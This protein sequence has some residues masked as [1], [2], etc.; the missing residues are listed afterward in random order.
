MP[1][2]AVLF[3][4][5][6]NTLGVRPSINNVSSEGEGGGAPQKEMK[7][8]MGRDPVVSRGDV[9][10]EGPKAIKD[11]KIMSLFHQSATLFGCPQKT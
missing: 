2:F 10:F 1:F 8:A 7:G 3:P 5:C 6:N 4:G 9:I 11:D